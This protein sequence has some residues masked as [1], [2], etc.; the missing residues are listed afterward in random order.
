MS[1]ALIFT[2]FLCRTPDILQNLEID[3]PSI[4]RVPKP[5]KRENMDVVNFLLSIAAILVPLGL[6]WLFINRK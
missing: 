2:F 5:L 6:A 1:G 3:L 4:V